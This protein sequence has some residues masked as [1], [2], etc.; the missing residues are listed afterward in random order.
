MLRDFRDIWDELW[1]AQEQQEAP[2]FQ[3]D[4]PAGK[5]GKRGKKTHKKS[6]DSIDFLGQQ[7]SSGIAES[8]T[9]SL[10]L[11]LGF[12]PTAQGYAQLPEPTGQKV[13]MAK[14]GS[15]LLA[16]LTIILEFQ[17]FPAQSKARGGLD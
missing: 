6:S 17:Y 9:F 4:H 3:S 11:L 2:A 14:D 7:W 13:G 5:I 12:F 10:S 15:S 8:T 1:A 16:L